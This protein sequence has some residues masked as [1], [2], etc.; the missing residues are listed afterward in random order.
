[1]SE[2]D[3]M[4]EDLYE[5]PPQNFH[6]PI[7]QKPFV[8]EDGIKSLKRWKP[9]EISE[10]LL[11]YVPH[12]FKK[13]NET[14][15]K[16]YKTQ[17]KIIQIFAKHSWASISIFRSA[18]KSMLSLGLLTWMICEYPRGRYFILGEERSKMRGRIRVI[19]K[20]LQTPKIMEDYGNLIDESNMKHRKGLDTAYSFLTKRGSYIDGNDFTAIEPTLLALSWRDQQAQGYHFDAGIFDDIWSIKLQNMKDGII[21]FM[22]WFSEFRHS[23]EVVE[24]FLML[25]TRKGIND[26]YAKLDS[27]KLWYKLEI[28][29]VKVWPSSDSYE[30]IETETEFKVKIL[31]RSGFKKANL[32]D[33]CKR[34]YDIAKCIL[35]RYRDP[36][37]FERE[38]QNRP[39]LPEG[40]IFR[41]DNWQEFSLEEGP[42]L[43]VYVVKL[44]RAVNMIQ[45]VLIMDMA[46][47]RNGDFNAFLLIGYYLN[48][49]WILKAWIGQDWSLTKRMKII[50]EANELYPEARI[51]IEEDYSQLRTILDIRERNPNLMIS[52]FRSQGKGQKYKDLFDGQKKAAKKGKIMDAME[53][54]F[55]NRLIYFERN[56]PYLKDSAESIKTQ[57]TMFPDCEIFDVIDALAMGILVLREASNVARFEG[58]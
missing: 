58:Y 57:L 9:K 34:K 40:K 49:Y 52:T 33:T 8:L 11:T 27:L 36:I 5:R 44:R 26:L 22:E 13:I 24:F 7:C 21:K 10:W 19:R 1:M 30:V 45:K 46:F 18:G 15:A 51:V 54:P 12:F 3:V 43:D 32:F 14:N 37:G 38:M 50:K 53:F 25:R 6:S 48:R 39:Y 17:K 16:L 56:I 2:I 55:N 23:L 41:V 42:A 20:A 35:M 4:L 28:P 29:L 47:G 31:N